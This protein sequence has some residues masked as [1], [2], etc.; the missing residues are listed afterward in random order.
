M[1]LTKE[2]LIAK[3]ELALIDMVNVYNAVSAGEATFTD[4]GR[5]VHEYLGDEVITALSKALIELK[6]E[7]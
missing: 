1:Q 5:A 2:E 3:M 4:A 6:E 7:C